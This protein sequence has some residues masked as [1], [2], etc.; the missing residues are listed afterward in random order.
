MNILIACDSNYYNKW[1]IDCILSIKTLAP[2]IKISVV[3]VNPENIKEIP[4]VN[5]FYD[6]KTFINDTSKISYYQSLRFIKCSELFPNGELVM[7]IDCDT[8]LFRPFT[9]EEFVNVTSEVHVQKHQKTDRWMAGLVTYGTDNSFRIRLKEELTKTPIDTWQ[10]GRDQNILENLS[11][12]F[13]FK[14]LNVGEWMSFGKGKGIFLT[15]K[16]DQK[17]TQKYLN[18]YEHVKSLYIK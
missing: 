17:T 6:E 10:Y 11:K 9:E 14:K 5:Y 18:N 15:L 12:E 16:G 1:A 4:D 8:L 13:K 3:I 7:T 2:F